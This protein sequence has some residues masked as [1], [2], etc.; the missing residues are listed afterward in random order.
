M[1][2]SFNQ[3]YFILQFYK[4]EFKTDEKE[5]STQLIL[6]SATMPTNIEDILSDIID[7]TTVTDVV[8]PSL[9]KILPHIKQHFVR[10]RKAEKSLELLALVKND[11]EKRRPVIVFANKAATTDYIE[12]FLKENGID[13]IS[14]N[15][16]L[17]NKI[18]VNQFRK[19]QEGEVN[20]LATTDVGSR[21]LDTTRVLFLFFFLHYLFQW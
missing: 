21:G 3:F 7:V 13:C 4:T 8:S 5:V 16:N 9:H 17:L 20:V 10:I 6:A 2:W 18:R 11:L 19:F 1:F 15:G 12:I 14:L